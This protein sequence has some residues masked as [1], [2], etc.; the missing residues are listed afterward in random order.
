MTIPRL[1]LH[2]G[3]AGTI[4]YAYN[5]IQGLQIHEV[6]ASQ[7][8]GSWQ[9]L[10]IQGIHLAELTLWISL[11]LDFYPSA[12]VLKLIKRSLLILSLPLNIVIA[13]IYWPLILFFPAALLQEAAGTPASDAMV[14]MLVYLPL[15]LDL[16]MHAVPAVA[17]A[18]DF[19]IYEQKF[20]RKSTILAPL[21]AF[22]Y[23]IF[24]GSWV[25][26]CSSRNNGVFP[27]PFLTDNTFNGRLAI[28]AGAA[29]A[30]P[31]VFWFLNGIHV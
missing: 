9:Y 7:Y 23:A 30:A 6:M 31:L 25:E 19:F 4:F 11:I 8:G 12:R 28:Y 27:Y 1:L 5:A 10:T 20:G 24:Y 2:A 29:S 15:H 3:G 21:L 17:L 16:A 18:V 13:S 26:H 14:D 22:A